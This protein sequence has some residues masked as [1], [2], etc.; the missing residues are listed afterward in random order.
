M[1]TAENRRN[2]SPNEV[3]SISKQNQE[4]S[5]TVE[6]SV[7]CIKERFEG[8][9]EQDLFSHEFYINEDS[10]MINVAFEEKDAQDAEDNE[11]I[12]ETNEKFLGIYL[13]K[14]NASGG[15]RSTVAMKV[16]IE[17]LEETYDVVEKRKMKKDETYGIGEIFSKDEFLNLQLPNNTLTLFCTVTLYSKERNVLTITRTRSV[18]MV[19]EEIKRLRK[20]KI[21]L[22]T[23]KERLF[24]DFSIESEDGKIIECHRVFLAS[25][26]TVFKAML[27]SNMKEA[28]EQRLKLDF[29]EEFLQHWVNFLYDT[30]IKKEIVM[31]YFEDFLHFSDKYDI[32]LLKLLTEDVL[33]KNLSTDLMLS[34]YT[35]GDLYNAENLKEAAKTF[36]VKNKECF[37]DQEYTS[38]LQKLNP[39]KIVEI[40]KII[41]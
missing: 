15:K 23:S 24:T 31:K 9:D 7:D 16:N 19:Q 39:E 37:K 5:T 10:F 20:E 6:F 4:F 17:G 14:T 26:S 3:S 1:S 32:Q 8:D 18:Q 28:K 2:I 13:K 27:Q 21:G 38:Q 11:E 12:E 33:I 25:Q 36:I 30:T 35:L 40:M 29:S 41:I 22:P 34:Y